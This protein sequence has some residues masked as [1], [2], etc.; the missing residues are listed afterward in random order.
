M[1]VVKTKKGKAKHFAYTPK[2]KA[3]AKAYA[4]KLNRRVVYG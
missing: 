4:K 2:G 1:P 3:K